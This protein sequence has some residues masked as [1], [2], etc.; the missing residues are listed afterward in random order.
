MKNDEVMFA[1]FCS[2]FAFYRLTYFTRIQ[3]F[4][5]LP[6]SSVQE[7]FTGPSFGTKN[8]FSFAPVVL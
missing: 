8:C 2:L 5:F 1:V 3:I 7:I 6:L 4:L